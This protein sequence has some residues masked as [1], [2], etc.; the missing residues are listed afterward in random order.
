MYKMY[1]WE[2][3]RIRTFQ[4]QVL[5]WYR[6]NKRKLFWR[7]QSDPYIIFVSEIMLQQTQVKKVERILPRFLRSFPSFSS[8]AQAP[9]K[10][11]IA[12]WQG[13]G[14][15]RRAVYLWKSAQ[16]I[17]NVYGGTLPHE[18]ALLL[19]LP[20]VG[21]YTASAV[22]VFAFNFPDIV[23][24]SN[25][26]RVFTRV[27]TRIRYKNQILPR[28]VIRQCV[29]ETLHHSN[30]KD[31]YYALMD[32]G[33]LV[34]KARTAV[35]QQCPL[36]KI[37]ETGKSGKFQQLPEKRR[38]K[39]EPCYQ[40]TPRRLW[41]GRILELFRSHSRFTVAEICSAVGLKGTKKD[42]L[43]IKE[44]LSQLETDLLVSSSV[45]SNSGQ[46]YYSLYQL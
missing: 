43:W 42:Q 10:D 5:S 38:Q 21:E 44:V 33:A 46:R 30:K 23:I 19:Q 12:L 36:L 16:E 29:A 27:S 39:N 2:E 4:A 11:V 31:W 17:V 32:L 25:I 41:R 13:L 6:R 8:L 9:L 34:C 22:R 26:E 40:G 28:K 20:G 35:C 14:Y 18:K 24:D 3:T 1:S 15:N 45:D 7:E 37:C